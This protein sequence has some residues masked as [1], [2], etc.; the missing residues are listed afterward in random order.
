MDEASGNRKRLLA[1][2]SCP[3]PLTHVRV[4]LESVSPA[5][6]DRF[7]ETQ[8]TEF[9]DQKVRAGQWSADDAPGLSR[10]VVEGFL[11]SE[12]PKPGHRVWKAL[13][14]SG[15]QVAWL[16][17]GPPPVKTLD[18]LS[19][20]WLYQITVEASLRGM[21]YG[22]ATLA[23]AEELLKREGV[24]ELYLNVF[25]WNTVARKL[26]DSAGYEVIHDGDTDTGMKKTLDG[27]AD[28]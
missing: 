1:E 6:Y 2:L 22:R 11:P 4:R 7:V 5:E 20:R 24:K 15:A 3:A 12:G 16:W 10:H 28:R 13:A 23:A 26:Y 17:V 18:I 14:E 27:E 9:A 19:R 25:R 8:I 21:G